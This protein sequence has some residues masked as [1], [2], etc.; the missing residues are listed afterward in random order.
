[1]ADFLNIPSDRTDLVVLFSIILGV[2]ILTLFFA[3]MQG[4]RKRKSAVVW[5]A[6]FI[7]SFIIL[8]ISFFIFHTG[9]APSRAEIEMRKNKAAS[10]MRKNKAESEQ[11]TKEQTEAEKFAKENGISVALAKS[12]E[13]ALAQ[14]EHSYKLHQIY[15]WEQIEDWAYGKKYTGWLDMEYVWVFYVKNDSLQSIRQQKDL[16]FIWSV[17][18]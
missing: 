5:I 1:M 11:V 2:T 13:S 9:D 15:S 8:I 18:E 10:E 12:I 6:C 17:K 7:I 4:A 3:I 16:R 14:S